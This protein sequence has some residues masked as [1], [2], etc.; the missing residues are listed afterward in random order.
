MFARRAGIYGRVNPDIMGG[1]GED[2]ESIWLVDDEEEE[3]EEEGETNQ[4]Q[5]REG[6]ILH[7]S[8]TESTSQLALRPSGSS[9]SHDSELHLQQPGATPAPAP[10]AE[11][12][13]QYQRPSFLDDDDDLVSVSPPDVA[14]TCGTTSNQNGKSTSQRGYAPISAS[15]LNITDLGIEDVDTKAPDARDPTEFPNKRP[16]T[17]T[18]TAEPSSSSAPNPYVNLFEQQD[19]AMTMGYLRQLEQL[20]NEGADEFRYVCSSSYSHPS[21]LS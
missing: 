13:F 20:N 6:Q 12:A 3:E 14:T 18:T 8:P 5:Q 10:S 16:R 1:F 7:T 21:Q 4:E 19:D 11:P 9:S 17:A 15:I 2:D